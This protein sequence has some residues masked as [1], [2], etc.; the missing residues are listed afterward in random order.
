LISPFCCFPPVCYR[1]REEEEEGWRRREVDVTRGI[2]VPRLIG[3]VV[4]RE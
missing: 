3:D 2:V 1:R 4:V